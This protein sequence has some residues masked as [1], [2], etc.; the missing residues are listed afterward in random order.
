MR[1]SHPS[2]V[3]LACQLNKEKRLRVGFL[4][5]TGIRQQRRCSLRGGSRAVA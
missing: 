4:R 1:A 3:L 2:S 5:L